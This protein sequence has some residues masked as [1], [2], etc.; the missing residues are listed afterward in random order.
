MVGCLASHPLPAEG[1]FFIFDIAMAMDADELVSDLKRL[2]VDL[3]WR[4][5]ELETELKKKTPI[6]ITCGRKWKR[7]FRSGPI[8]TIL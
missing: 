7:L 2:T 8:V 3:A 6:L 4:L 1:E 5:T